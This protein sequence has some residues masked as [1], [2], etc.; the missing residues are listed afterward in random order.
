VAG[1]ITLALYWPATLLAAVGPAASLAL[2]ASLPWWPRKAALLGIAVAASLTLSSLPL[3]LALLDTPPPRPRGLGPGRLY[4]RIETEADAH[5]IAPPEATTSVRSFFRRAP[6]ELWPLTATRVGT[7]YAFD[8]DPDG[9]YAD[10]DRALRKALEA[11]P[12]PDR[13]AELRVAGVTTVIADQP[14]PPPYA[15]LAVIDAERGVRAYTLEGAAPSV[16]VA[17]RVL[18][19][20]GLDAVMAAHRDP[21]FAPARDVVL[22]GPAPAAPAQATEPGHATVV[23]ESPAALVADVDTKTAG[24]VVWSRT[25]FSAWN[26]T[27]DGGAAATVRADGHLVGVPV[28]AGRSRVELRWRATPVHIGLGLCMVGLVLVTILRRRG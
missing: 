25:Y 21:A 16:R 13:A 1:A 24:V 26:A 5:P 28:P 23:S 17:T 10:E 9:A 22:E 7:G 18:A 8:F 14:L 19:V 4:S 12:W 20:S 2:A 15:P 27:I 11:L 6:A 3:L